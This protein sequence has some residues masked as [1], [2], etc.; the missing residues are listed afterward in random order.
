MIMIALRTNNNYFDLYFVEQENLENPFSDMKEVIPFS[1]GFQLTFHDGPAAFS[2]KN[3]TIYITRSY[4]DRTVKKNQIKN[5]RLKIF[6][7]QTNGRNWSDEKPFFL[8]SESYSVA[9]PSIGTDGK[10]IYFSSDMPSGYGASDIWFCT[11]DNDKW[12]TPVNLGK[13]VNTFGNEGFPFIQ[14]IGVG[15]R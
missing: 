9:H 5:H 10:T 3:G 1:K 11:W 4:N 14:E 15:V 13:E 7:A 2:P 8:N 6:V 12:S